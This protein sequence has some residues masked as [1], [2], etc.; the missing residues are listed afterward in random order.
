MRRGD[1]ERN[2]NLL[3]ATKELYYIAFGPALSERDTLTY[4]IA[5]KNYVAQAT[6]GFPTAKVWQGWV[7]APSTNIG[8]KSHIRRVYIRHTAGPSHKSPT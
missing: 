2:L 4:F 8:P 3:R 1:S 6:A 7:K 5:G